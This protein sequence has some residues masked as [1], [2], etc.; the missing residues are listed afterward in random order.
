MSPG[1]WGPGTYLVG[2]SNEMLCLG[3]LGS[4]HREHKPPLGDTTRG[5]GIP[6]R[7]L[8]PAIGHGLSQAACVD[9]IHQAVRYIVNG[10]RQTGSRSLAVPPLSGFLGEPAFFRGCV[11]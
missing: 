4:C 1:H 7:T 5:G 10:V 8:S 2:I 11:M 3:Q 9:F 6:R